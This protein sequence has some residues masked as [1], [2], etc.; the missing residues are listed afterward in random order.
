MA[1]RIIQVNEKVPATLL[2]RLSLQ[3]TLAMFGASVLVPIVLKFNPGIVLLMNDSSSRES[4]CQT[5]DSLE[6][7]TY[8]CDVWC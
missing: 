3:H 8:V 2:I 7:S 5:Y 4:P 6:H 1:K